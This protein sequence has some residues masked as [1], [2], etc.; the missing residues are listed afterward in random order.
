MAC[1]FRA[2]GSSV[3]THGALLLLVIDRLNSFYEQ[4]S[5][6]GLCATA[7]AE[8]G[9]ACGRPCSVQVLGWVVVGL[10]VVA[11]LCLPLCWQGCPLLL[12]LLQ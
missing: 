9:C 12:T 8:E 2:D 6:R 1:C 3:Q 4:W 7:A 10:V 5:S 11:S